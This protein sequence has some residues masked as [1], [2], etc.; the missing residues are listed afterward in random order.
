MQFTYDIGQQT[1]IIIMGIQAGKKLLLSILKVQRNY[2]NKSAHDL[3]GVK[4]G[5]EFIN[6]A[7]MDEPF[8]NGA[9]QRGKLLPKVLESLL[10]MRPQAY[11][12]LSALVDSPFPADSI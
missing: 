10:G 11:T 1:Y 2:T 12:L 8:V 4:Y 9:A 7:K 5:V 6:L 3:I